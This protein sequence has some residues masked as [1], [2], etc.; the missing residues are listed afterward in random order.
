MVLS[1][2]K[3][4][5]NWKIDINFVAFSQYNIW[6]WLEQNWEMTFNDVAFLKIT[7]MGDCILLSAIVQLKRQAKGLYISRAVRYL[8]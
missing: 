1:L 5:T 2:T 6:T 3:V 7:P 8:L 4:K